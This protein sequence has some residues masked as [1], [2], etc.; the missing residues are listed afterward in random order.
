METDTQEYVRS[1]VSCQKNKVTRYKKYGE[2]Y[3][4]TIPH[5]PWT[6]ISMDFIMQLPPSNKY[7]QIWVVADR[8]TKMAHFIPLSSQ[9]APELAVSFLQHIWKHYGLPTNIV[10]D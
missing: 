1:C 3:P 8:F 2:L 6:Y 7:N 10:F 9:T 5:R 4:H